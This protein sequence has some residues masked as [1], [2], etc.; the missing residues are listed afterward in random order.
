MEDEL[1]LAVLDSR[2][3]GRWRVERD[4]EPDQDRAERDQRRVVD[5][6]ADP[7]EYQPVA[8]VFIKSESYVFLMTRRVLRCARSVSAPK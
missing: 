3:T 1:E 8:L 4:I 6:A 7:G 2:G 5:G